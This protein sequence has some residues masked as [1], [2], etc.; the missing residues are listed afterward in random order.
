M[1]SETVG[2]MPKRINGARIERGS[3]QYAVLDLTLCE[4]PGQE[5][6][7]LISIANWR[8]CGEL[9]PKTSPRNQIET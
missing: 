9:Q 6:A 7:G 2:I 1:T 4:R 8:N 5:V 3:T